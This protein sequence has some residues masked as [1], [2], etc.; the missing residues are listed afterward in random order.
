M[1]L[2]KML[3]LLAVMLMT[4]NCIIADRFGAHNVEQTKLNYGPENATNFAGYVTVNKTRHLFYWFFESR[5][6]PETD[7]FVLWMTG[8]PGCSSLVAL[9]YENGPYHISK[10]GPLTNFTLNPYSWNTAANILFIDQPVGAGYSYA[11]PGDPGVF[12]EKAMAENMWEFFQNFFVAYPKYSK[13]QFFIFGESYAGHYVPAL[14]AYIV[15]AN[16]TA[17]TVINIQGAAVG[18]GLVD[19]LIQYAYYA[20]FALEHQLVK[21][22][23]YDVM[24]AAVKPCQAL[25]KECQQTPLG[26]VDCENAYVV[27]NYAEVV[28]IELTGINLYDVREKCQVPPLCY[29]FSRLEALAKDSSFMTALGVRGHSWKEC[30]RITEEKL[31]LAGDWMLQY[32]QSIPSLLASGGR[33]MIYAGEDDFIC[34]WLGNVEWTKVM[35]WPGQ[36]AYNA[37]P[38]ITWT[39]KDGSVAGSTVSANNFTFVKVLN[40]GHMV[41]MNQPENALDMMLR[42]IRNQPFD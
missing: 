2:G 24:K 3:Y 25:I 8:G 19:P 34:N 17:P 31:V 14:S 30:N 21:Q 28:P 20:D 18:N 5:S 1:S 22:A 4:A 11:D 16:P 15:A 9:F 27:C 35:V 6:S 13:L 32:Q 37:A 12:T 38:N 40:A 36:A 29:D 42:F 23:E 39:A 26:I 41:P 10:T 7:P 33:V